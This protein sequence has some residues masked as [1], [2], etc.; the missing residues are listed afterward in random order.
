[1]IFVISFE[2]C[3]MLVISYFRKFEIFRSSDI[4]FLCRNPYQQSVYMRC[5]PNLQ[6]GK[7]ARKLNKISY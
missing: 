5:T 6:F 4:E 7:R 2:T 1:M 3:V